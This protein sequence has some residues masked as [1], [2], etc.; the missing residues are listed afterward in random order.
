LSLG[1]APVVGYTTKSIYLAE[2]LFG[3][4]FSRRF[5]LLANASVWSSSSL[6]FKLTLLLV[7]M[8]IALL[9]FVAAKNLLTYTQFSLSFPWV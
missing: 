7:N 5:L 3:E 1:I 2:K 8:R 4:Y 6:G 9:H